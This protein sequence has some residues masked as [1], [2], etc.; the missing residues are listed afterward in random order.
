MLDLEYMQFAST[1]SE[2]LKKL[3]RRNFSIGAL[4]I[5]KFNVIPAPPQFSD[6]SKNVFSIL[7]RLFEKIIGESSG[8]SMIYVG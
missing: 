1:I 2:A 6:A 3:D 7:G 8:K 5:S 4:P